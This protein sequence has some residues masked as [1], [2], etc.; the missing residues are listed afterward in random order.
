LYLDDEINLECGVEVE[1]PFDGNDQVFCSRTPGGLVATTS[2][3][4]PYHLL[5]EAHMA[6][7]NWCA[8]Q[9]HVLAGPNWEIY[10]HWSDDP[11]QLQTDVFYLL[12]E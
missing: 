12:K 3:L 6:I 4:G 11:A 5:G 7:R 10:G 8:E 9:G 1:Q 2:H